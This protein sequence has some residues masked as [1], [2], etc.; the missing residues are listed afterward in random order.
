MDY[1]N[2]SGCV[3]AGALPVCVGN[4][5]D[6]ETIWE[7]QDRAQRQ[8]S[9]CVVDFWIE[10]EMMMCVSISACFGAWLVN[11]LWKNGQC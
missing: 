2:G 4:G 10:D 1:D 11:F 9:V 3:A 7:R 6:Q 8:E 5:S